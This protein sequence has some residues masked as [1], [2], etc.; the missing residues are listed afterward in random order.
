M[1][2]IGGFDGSVSVGIK[3]AVTAIKDL[4]D[5]IKTNNEISQDQNNK[6][7]Q[8]T[9]WL[10]FLTVAIGLLTIIQVIAVFCK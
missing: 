7:V 6:M 8:Y 1:S 3:E 4:T 5:T 2:G 9:R 10:F